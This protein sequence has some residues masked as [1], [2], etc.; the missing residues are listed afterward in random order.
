MDTSKL[1][2]LGRAWCGNEIFANASYGK[3]DPSP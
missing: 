1:L 3:M 2:R